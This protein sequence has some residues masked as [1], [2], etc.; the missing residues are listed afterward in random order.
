MKKFFFL[1][2]ILCLCAICG[3]RAQI[4]KNGTQWWDG[5]ALYTATVDQD[6]DVVMNGITQ[7]DGNQKFCLSKAESAGMYYLTKDNPDAVMPVNG[8]MGSKV[9]FVREGSNTFLRIL[10]RKREVTHQLELT[11]KTLAELTED[12]R[13]FAEDPEYNADLRELVDE[14][15]YYAGG[16]ADDGRGPEVIDGVAT[17]S[18]NSAREFINALGSDRTIIVAEDTHINLSDVLEIQ[19]AFEGYPDR[20][21]GMQ[22]SDLIGPKSLILSESETDGQQLALLNMSNLKIKGAKN[23]SI[24]VN[25]R[26]AFCL[27]FVN[28]ANCAVENLTI[29]HTVGGFCSGGVI[30]VEQSSVTV[31]DCDLYGCGTYGLDLRDTYNFRLIN[32]S[33]HDCTYGIIQMN[34][35]TLTTFERCDFFNNREYGLIEGWGNNGVKFDDC[36]FFANWGDSKL[37]FFDSIFSLINCKVYHPSENLGTMDKS[38]NRGSQF[39]D[40]PL[41][42]SIM[43]RGVGPDQN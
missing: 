38:V 36:R 23:S 30:G 18:V 27:K 11:T 41:D 15:D 35:C 31:K 26:Y 29:G 3:V 42:S 7:A 8:T 25:P 10:N 4:V 9:Q 14:G 28:C 32:S 33:I 20:R 6:G 16:L 21:W 22:S 19:K 39:I 5:K 12:T 40:N 43:N 24:E 37:F 1:T 17:W 13:N 2:T 34:K